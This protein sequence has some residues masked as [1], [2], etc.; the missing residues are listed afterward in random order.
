[1]P[2]LEPRVRESL[3]EL[4]PVFAGAEAAMGFLP[5]SMLTMAHMPQLTMAFSMLAGVTFG[6]DLRAL[7]EVYKAGV[8]TDAN[9]DQAL[10]PA[11]V[12]LIAYCVSLSAGCRYCQAHTSHNAHRAGLDEEKFA[13]VLS[14]ETSDKF[15][16]A[17]KALIGVA[18]AAGQVPNDVDADHFTALKAH[19]SDRQIVQI[20]GVISLFG[21]LN[22]WN[23]TMATSLEE[24]PINFA[25]RVLGSQGWE[26]SKHG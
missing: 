6:A 8:P 2:H 5:N 11:H 16:G 20:V 4:A 15:D 19:F 26:V 12:Q 22:R 1:M 18:L 17:E 10:A 7:M 25:Q 21:F 23:D 9:A 14:Y 13:D 3:P 24:D